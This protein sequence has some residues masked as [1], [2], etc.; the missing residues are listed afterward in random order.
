[1]SCIYLPER[2]SDDDE[3][4][5]VHAGQVPNHERLQQGREEAL[6]QAGGVAS[7][8]AATVASLVKVA[9]W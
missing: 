1:M 3:P 2:V 9:R 4:V 7:A 6:E 8:A 5:E